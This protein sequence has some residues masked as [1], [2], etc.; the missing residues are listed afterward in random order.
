[1]TANVENGWI[2]HHKDPLWKT[3]DIDR[4]NAY[5]IDDLIPMTRGE[6]NKI[7]EHFHGHKHTEETKLKQAKFA[8]GRIF[9]NETR[10]KLSKIHKNKKFSEEHNKKISKAKIGTHLSEETKRKISEARIGSHTGL[11]FVW[12]ND[13]KVNTRALK[14]P[15]EGWK[16]GLLRK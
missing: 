13:G 3:E 16:R 14:C 11:G 8:T 4:Y 10:Q 1:M 12:W 9:S 2:L 15:G 6:H 7:H 5:N